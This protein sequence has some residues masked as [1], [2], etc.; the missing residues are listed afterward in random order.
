MEVT[1]EEIKHIELIT[2]KGRVDS[3]NAPGL[4]KAL[5]SALRRGKYKIVV[6]LSQV[7]YMSSAGLRALG[8]AQRHSQQS[9]QGEVVLAQVPPLIGEALELVGFTDF[10]H[11]EESVSAALAFAGNLPAD[12]SHL[13][14]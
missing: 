6:D 8:D 13:P 12:D 1:S 7:D 10:F 14:A 4:V 2:V 11:I 3:M 9:G 5:E